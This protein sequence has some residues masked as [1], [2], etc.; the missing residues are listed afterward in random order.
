MRTIGLAND[1]AGTALKFKIK[2]HLE[3]LGYKVVN[4][5][6]DNDESCNYPIFGEKLAMGI[7]N[8]ECDLGIAI[9]GTGVGISIACNKVKGIRAGVCSEVKTA[10]L[11]VEHNNAQILA[12]GARIVDETTAINLVDAFLSAKHDTDNP[13]HDQ[14]IAM[15]KDIEDRQ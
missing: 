7:K 15:L 11:I 3:S 9:C 8:K 10:G 12:F 13:R 4:Y 2:E 5:G 6:T 14:R 1:H